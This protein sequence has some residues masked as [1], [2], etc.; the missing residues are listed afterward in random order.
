MQRVLCVFVR[1]EKSW[2]IEAN[3][4]KN[5][6][7]LI[8]KVLK[9]WTKWNKKS[10]FKLLLSLMWHLRKF[11]FSLHRMRHLAEPHAFSHEVFAFIYNKIASFSFSLLPLLCIVVSLSCLSLAG[12]G[13]GWPYG[14]PL[15][16]KFFFF[17]SLSMCRS[18]AR[19]FLLEREN[20]K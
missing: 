11:K 3:D 12:V 7:F 8:R 1:D 14:S 10:I 16:R 13:D 20:V 17:F 18:I 15:D 9:H 2:N 6:Y 4:T 5:I 19:R